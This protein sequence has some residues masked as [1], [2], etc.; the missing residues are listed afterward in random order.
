M[1]VNVIITIKVT[2]FILNN[3]NQLQIIWR[4]L[5]TYTFPC[6]LAAFVFNKLLCTY[7]IP[8]IALHALHTLP[9]L[10]S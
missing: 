3:I 10:I 8:G 2:T 1:I 4:Y 9:Y 7:Y 5:K 6:Y